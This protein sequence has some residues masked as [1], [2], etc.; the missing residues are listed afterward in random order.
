ML[1]AAIMQCHTSM[2]VLTSASLLCSSLEHYASLMVPPRVGA[3][4][5]EEAGRQHAAVGQCAAQNRW[6]CCLRYA[7]AT[8]HQAARI[9]VHS[10]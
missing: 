2:H 3:A 1:L 5:Q 6:A 7:R 4:G 8:V 9:A 10:G